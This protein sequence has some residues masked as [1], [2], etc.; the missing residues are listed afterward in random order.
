MSNL[1]TLGIAFLLAQLGHHAAERFTARL[2]E[3]DLTP[4][5]AAI[6]RAIAGEPGRSQQALSEQL[7][8]LPSRVVAFIDDLEQ[9]ELL[10]RR[11]NPGDRRLYALYLT[12][13]GEAL[14]TEL[15]ELAGAHEDEIT[16][17]LTEHQR[18][19]LGQLLATLADR[20]QLSQDLPPA[21]SAIAR[22]RHQP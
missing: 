14:M 22:S 18:T 6:L 9:R 20:Q 12:E 17:G 4:P 1:P 16:A 19:V 21:Y 2:A 8:L 3:L 7:G 10:Q 11:R 13:Q 5:Q 15:A